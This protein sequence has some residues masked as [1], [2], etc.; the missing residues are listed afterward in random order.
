MDAFTAASS[1]HLSTGSTAGNAITCSTTFVVSFFVVVV[2]VVVV[3]FNV[4]AEDVTRVWLTMKRLM[5]Q[6]VLKI[7]Y[8]VYTKCI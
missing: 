2:D 5:E 4:V 3:G 1:V 7:I 8:K 6:R